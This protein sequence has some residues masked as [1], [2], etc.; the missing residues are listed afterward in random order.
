MAPMNLG[1]KIS[2]LFSI[3][4][5]TTLVV[6]LVSAILIA[7]IFILNN[8]KKTKYSY[9]VYAIIL[10]II[11]ITFNKSLFPLVDMFIERLFYLFYFPTGAIYMITLIISHIIFIITI[12]S[13]KMDNIVKYINYIGFGLTQVLCIN[14]LNYLNNNNIDLTNELNFV[15]NYTMI[16]ILELSMLIFVIWMGIVI[17]MTVSKRFA[18]AL[19]KEEIPVPQEEVVPSKPIIKPIIDYVVNSIPTKQESIPTVLATEKIKPVVTETITKPV[20]EPLVAKEEVY[21]PKMNQELLNKLLQPETTNVVETHVTPVEEVKPVISTKPNWNE[22][23]INALNIPNVPIYNDVVEYTDNMVQTVVEETIDIP[24]MNLDKNE[25][26]EEKK[27]V[28]PTK[29]LFQMLLR[30]EDDD[31]HSLEDYLELKK[32]LVAQK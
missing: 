12:G 18:Y 21:E 9:I 11:G 13:K 3:F 5:G 26:K 27:I 4:D 32:Y 1:E 14:I 25:V 24:N 28:N 16:G 10:L 17:F 30:K 22:A 15:H 19:L 23:V 20:I 6:M 2:K 31:N 29:E 7:L 8:N